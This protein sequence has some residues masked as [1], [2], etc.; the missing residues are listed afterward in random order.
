MS[1]AFS[2]SNHFLLAMPSQMGGYFGNTVTYI[3]EHSARGAFGIMVNRPTDLKVAELLEQLSPNTSFDDGI[4]V[5]E[6]GPVERGRG[7]VLHSNDVVLEESMKM[8]DTLSLT[9]SRSIL[10]AIREREGPSKYLVALGYSGWG[11]G[12]LEEEMQESAWL[13]CPADERVLFEV[14]F[15]DRLDA[16]AALLGIDLRL[17]VPRRGEA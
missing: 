8:T 15:H 1:T 17:L 9:T 3:C 16:V 7:F 4:Y 10:D 14:P 5:L 6:G 13:S 2:L 12:Q 11:P